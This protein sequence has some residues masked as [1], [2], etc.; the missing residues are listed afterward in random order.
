MVGLNF[1]DDP[2]C[3]YGPNTTDATYAGPLGAYHSASS[4]CHG[5]NLRSINVI[6]ALVSICAN[7]TC[8]YFAYRILLSRR[9]TRYNIFMTLCPIAGAMGSTVDLFAASTYFHCGGM[10]DLTQLT[11]ICFYIGT[12]FM[13]W[14]Q[15]FRFDFILIVM[16][17]NR[18]I[19]RRAVWVNVGIWCALGVFTIAMWIQGR[20]N[21]PKL[22]SYAIPYAFWLFYVTFLDSTLSMVLLHISLRQTA[23]LRSY[24]LLTIAQVKSFSTRFRRAALL[25]L[26]IIVIATALFML[27][28]STEV[29]YSIGMITTPTIP[30]QLAVTI[31]SI[32]T[33]QKMERLRSGGHKPQNA[34]SK[35]Q[36]K[37]A[38]AGSKV[39]SS[40]QGLVDPSGMGKMS[41]CIESQTAASSS[42]VAR[43]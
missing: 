15:E 20:W 3:V 29:G 1:V 37:S 25:H 8:L 24:D 12:F 21:Q 30:A 26:T 9:K 2:G 32:H 23:L 17:K 42:A 40:A 7:L 39:V 22:I 16:G 41:T 35:R 18:A 31:Y 4:A 6:F 38:T 5:L 28:G 33:L 14:V 13:I 19:A 11:K 43:I 36:D 27:A 34:N 10:P